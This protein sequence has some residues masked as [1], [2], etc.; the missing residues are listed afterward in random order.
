MANRRLY[1][2]RRLLAQRWIGVAALALVVH[3]VAIDTLHHHAI[4][5]DDRAGSV[6]TMAPPG[7]PGATSN[8]GPGGC[9]ACQLQQNS[10][11]EIPRIAESFAVETSSLVL[12][13]ERLEAILRSGDTSPP[14]RAP[15]VL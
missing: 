3:A 1:A 15:P 14:D 8:E 13:T 7:G 4:A 6:A 5:P 11:V 12:P 10:I 2:W 9:P